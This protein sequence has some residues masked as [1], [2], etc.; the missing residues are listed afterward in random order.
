MRFS[1]KVGNGPRNKGLNFGG[2]PHP[3]RDTVKTCLGGGMHCHSASSWYYFRTSSTHFS[4]FHHFSRSIWSW[5]MFTADS[6]AVGLPD[7]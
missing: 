3:N 4:H 2:E 1:G 5:R 6:H 7:L